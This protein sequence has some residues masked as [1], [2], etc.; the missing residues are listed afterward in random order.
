LKEKNKLQWN[1]EKLEPNQTLLLSYIM[2]SKVKPVGSV[3]LPKANV[4]FVDEK[5]KQRV[6]SSN[7]VLVLT[8]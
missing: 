6:V 7:K 8:S 5:D 1:F 3:E 2:Y 4:S